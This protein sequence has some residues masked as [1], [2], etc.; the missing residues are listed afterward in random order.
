MLG[1]K[2]KASYRLNWVFKIGLE[3]V[4]EISES[5]S[6]KMQIAYLINYL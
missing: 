6:D 5:R 1:V 2:S 4:D 3:V